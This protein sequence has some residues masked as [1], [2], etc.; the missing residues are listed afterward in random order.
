MELHRKHASD[1]PQELLD[2]FHEYQHGHITRRDFLE[3]AQKFAAAGVTAMAL[4]ES[5]KPN[6]AWAQQV[7]TDTR[8]SR[9]ATKPSSRRRATAA[10]RA[11]SP[12]RPAAPRSSPAC[13]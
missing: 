6:Y 8:A 9:P 1:Y 7:K 4:Y 13:W 5:L 10:S 12:G 3:R 11:T 2:L